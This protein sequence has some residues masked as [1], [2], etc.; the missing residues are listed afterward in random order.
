M[1]SIPVAG[2]DRLVLTEHIAVMDLMALADA[3]LLPDD[4]LA[5]A[6]VLKSPLFGLSDEQLFELAW[7]RKGSLRASLR[8]K[9]RRSG[10]C[11][12]RTRARRARAG[13]RASS[14]RS[15]SS[16]MCWAPLRG[17]AKFLARLGPEANDALDEFLN[18][19]LDYETRETPSLQGFLAW[20]RAAQSEVKRDME[21]VRDEVR[22]MTVHGAK[23]LEADTVIL[24]DTTTPPG[25][26][27]DPR[28]LHAAKTV[29]LV[30]ATA[31][32]EDVGAMTDARALAQ[33]DARDEYRRLLYVAMTRAEERLVICG[34]QGA[35]QNSRRLLV[36]TGRGRAE[37]RLR[38]RAGRRR[39]RRGVA[40]PQRRS[41]EH[42]AA[43][44]QKNTLPAATKPSS[45]AELAHANAS[46]EI[47]AR[48]HHHA[49]E[50]RR[51]TTPRARS[52]AGGN[53]K[54]LLRG[55]LVH[56]LLQSLPDIP[57]ERRARRRKT[58][59]P[60]PAPNWPPRSARR[61]PSK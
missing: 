37:A 11:R 41:S 10:V 18:L 57:A 46:S 59:S 16:P 17:R 6:S 56:R 55:A 24:A 26:P 48:A 2:A 43:E 60:E 36:S 27:R 35:Q 40:L 14:R 42:R 22:V 12:N 38:V 20:L 44:D 34:T 61:S 49:V 28:L 54:A 30:W 13:A 32:G 51:M 21:M 58:I 29:A 15:A 45:A 1:P 8:A 31:R 39:R 7:D 3:L 52:R 47:S 9:A 5:L 50:R 19:A 23:G 33:Q 53:A 4:D 25:G